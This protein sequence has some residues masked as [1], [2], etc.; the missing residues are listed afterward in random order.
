MKIEN[1]I[2]RILPNEKV[3]ASCVCNESAKC[4]ICMKQ[5]LSGETYRSSCE[6]VQYH[7]F[8]VTETPIINE[9]QKII[10]TPKVPANYN[11]SINAMAIYKLIQKYGISMSFLSYCLQLY[12]AGK[13]ISLKLLGGPMLFTVII[14]LSYPIII[15]I[16][17]GH[18]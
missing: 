7:A 15:N 18:K 13:F 17:I 6:V 1:D 2:I 9:I 16:C 11:S 5:Y 3:P 8:K 4:T 12:K 10:N 14:L